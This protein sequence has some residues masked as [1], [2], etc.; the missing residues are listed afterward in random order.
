MPAEVVFPVAVM[1]PPLNDDVAARNPIAVTYAC[2]SVTAH[3]VKRTIATYG[4]CMTLR[5]KDAR[6]LTTSLHLV[7]R[8]ISK[9]DGGIAQAFHARPCEIVVGN[10]GD[11][12]AA[13]RYRGAVGYGDAGFRPS[14]TRDQIAVQQRHFG[15]RGG[16]YHWRSRFG[17]VHVDVVGAF[18]TA[19][20]QVIAGGAAVCAYG[21]AL[22]VVEGDAG[23]G[24]VVR[25][26]I[27]GVVEV[28]VIAC[29]APVQVTLAIDEIGASVV[30]KKVIGV[31]LLPELLCFL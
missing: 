30:W 21:T 14:R 17:D 1:L 27:L 10:G 12:H 31:P 18:A 4:D 25:Q 11:V 5:D 29:R 20:I 16:K 24:I 2:T 13:K 22:G 3:G 19:R 28:Y 7:H 23:D 9:D 26:G 15:S 6:T 8:P